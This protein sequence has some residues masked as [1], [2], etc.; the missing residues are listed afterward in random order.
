MGLY[1]RIAGLLSGPVQWISSVVA[2]GFSQA[3]AVSGAGANIT[4]APQ[5][6]TTTG[7]SGS[8]V[9]NVAAPAGATTTEA[10]F[11]FERGGTV[12]GRIQGFI[13]FPTTIGAL[14]AGGVSPSGSNFALGWSVDG[15]SLS[16]NAATS[17]FFDVGGVSKLSLLTGSLTLASGCQLIASSSG[18]V[19]AGSF[20]QSGTVVG[21]SGAP[22]VFGNSAVTLATSGTTSLSAAQQQTP[23]LTVAA[24]TLVGAAVLDFG[25]VTGNFQLN[26]VGV[27][28]A[29]FASFGLS[30]KNGTTTTAL[31]STALTNGGLVIVRCDPNLLAFC[32]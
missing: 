4:I 6:A 26:I 28:A 7:A 23:N 13:G 31:P 2:P 16:F 10:A 17:M 11:G 19:N 18:I 12:L 27:N 15:T 21:A 9:V 25:N 8:V 24:V 14:Y 20:S 29:S 3:A 32:A 5:A 22:F 1:S 30:L